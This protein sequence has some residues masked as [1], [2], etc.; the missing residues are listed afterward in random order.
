M[1]V[2]CVHSPIFVYR[3]SVRKSYFSSLFYIF[4][5]L[6]IPDDFGVFI[7]ILGVIIQCYHYSFCSNSLSFSHWRLIQV[8]SYVT[9]TY[10]HYFLSTPLTYGITKYSRLILY[11]L[12]PCSGISHFFKEP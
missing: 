11:L 7:F 5:H 3:Y 4:S 8:S 12:L 1:A 9:L 6:F 10:L 2:F